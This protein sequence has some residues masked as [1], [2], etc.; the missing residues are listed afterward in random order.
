MLTVV[1]ALS[2]VSHFYTSPQILTAPQRVVEKTV[3]D[4]GLIFICITKLLLD[5]RSLFHSDRLLI[6]GFITKDIIA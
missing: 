3:S 5:I 1:S 6:W 4:Q 2:N